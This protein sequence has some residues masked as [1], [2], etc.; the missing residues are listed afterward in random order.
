[1]NEQQKSQPII[2]TVASAIPAHLPTPPPSR[3]SGGSPV[4]QI[5][6][7]ARQQSPLVATKSVQPTISQPITEITQKRLS[8]GAIQ[9]PSTQIPEH[10]SPIVHN[11]PHQQNVRLTEITPS[12]VGSS[13]PIQLPPNMAKFQQQ[14]AAQRGSLS[15][16]EM[17]VIANEMMAKKQPFMQQQQT[18][19][20]AMQT[21]FAPPVPTQQRS[22]AG[23][24]SAIEVQT[25]IQQQRKPG[26]IT[27][28]PTSQIP[29]Q[30]NAIRPN[31]TT[32][33]AST[34]HIQTPITTN[35]QAVMSQTPDAYLGQLSQMLSMNPALNNPVMMQ[36]LLNSPQFL[37]QLPHLASNP[38][39]LEMFVR[40]FQSV[41]QN[42]LQHVEFEKLIKSVVQM[43]GPTAP[44][45]VVQ[46]AILSLYQQQQVR[47]QE[48]EFVEKQK[49]MVLNAYHEDLARRQAMHQQLHANQPQIP[50]STTPNIGPVKQYQNRFDEVCF[51]CGK[52]F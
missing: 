27:A 34:S 24:Q 49:Q 30:F 51:K 14:M 52:G 19:T 32:Q 12:L 40:N 35:P 47:H 11:Q 15:E 45:Q 36:Q 42:N 41:Q 23:S 33:P 37:A 18:P 28:I 9:P 29:Q 31:V 17:M 43:V 20:T 25:P 2:T 10:V 6:Y 4:T 1:M 13:G 48:H 26:S 7:P 50:I 3:S 8:D 22:R 44:P 38:Q 46:Q 16:Q 5:Q 39:A 21:P